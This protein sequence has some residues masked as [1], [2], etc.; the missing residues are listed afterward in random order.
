MKPAFPAIYSTLCPIALSSLISEK[1]QLENVQ[2][3]FLVRGVGDTYLVESAGTRFILR[4]YRSSHRSLPQIKE[5]VELLLALKQAD[6]PVSYPI[7]DIS[8]QAILTL[9]AAE[10]E[11]HAVLFSYAPGHAVKLLNENQLRS[12]GREMARFHNVSAALSVGGARWNF[13]F[14]TTVSKPLEMLKPAFAEDPEGYAWLREVAEQVRK[15]LSALHSSG[16]SKG[17][18][19]FDFLPKNFHFEHD[20][21]T[22]FDF[23]FMG[24]G[25]LVNDIMTFWQHLVLDVYTGRMQRKAADDAYNILLDEY[26]A[27]RPVSEQE[28]AAVPYLAIGFW[29]FYMGFHT[30]HDQF[31]AFSQPSHVKSYVGVL[32]HI[33][34]TYWDMEPAH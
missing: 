29:L 11:R 7:P 14:Q 28:L 33:V 10:G 16:C 2:C 3:S 30:T 20:S 17:Y 32:R 15:K 18:C 25:C 8:G 4:V 26:R 24:Y 21:V 19:H 5:E 1:Y 6:V 9:E 22:F 13:D 34:A 27:Y 12:L 31:Y 23:D